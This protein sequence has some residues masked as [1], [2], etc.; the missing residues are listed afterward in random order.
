MIGLGLLIAQTASAG[1]V[2]VNGPNGGIINAFA[3]TGKNILA[4]TYGSGVFMSTDT[5]N[6][7][8]AVNNGITNRYIK[9]LA[10]NDSIILAATVTFKNGYEVKT[11][12]IFFSINNVSA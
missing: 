4:G 12:G 9:S 10:A 11:G 2:Q 8:I 1:W 6:N 5:G 7:W 3:S